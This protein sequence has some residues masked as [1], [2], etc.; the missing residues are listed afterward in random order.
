MG[1]YKGRREGG[2]LGEYNGR[3]EEV[4][5]YRNRTGESGLSSL[6]NGLGDRDW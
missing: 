1:E 5:E 2:L 4:L 3:G 6:G